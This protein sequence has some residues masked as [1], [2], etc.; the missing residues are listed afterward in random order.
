MTEGPGV[1]LASRQGHW[2][3]AATVLGSGPA[4]IDAT[5]VSI[6]LPGI[7]RLSDASFV[8]RSPCRCG[9]RRPPS[10]IGGPR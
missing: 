7:V 8:W 1:P 2:L 5:V 10:S 3:L 4:G 6:A 9:R